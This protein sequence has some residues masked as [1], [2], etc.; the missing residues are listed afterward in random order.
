MRALADLNERLGHEAGDAALQAVARALRVTFR[1]SDVV[2]RIGGTLFTVLALDLHE[3]D[4]PSVEKRIMEHLTNAETVRY[5]GDLIDVR[6]GWNTP[7]GDETS[8][9]ELIGRA[10]RSRR[11]T[12]Y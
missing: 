3:G 4:R 11:T 10:A 2:S 12:D 6:L 8:L 9:E 7:A 1:K 5:V